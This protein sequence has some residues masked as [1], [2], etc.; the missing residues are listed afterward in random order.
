MKKT[1]TYNLRKQSKLN[2]IETL[3]HES[4]LLKIPIEEIIFLDKHTD[5]FSKSIILFLIKNNMSALDNTEHFNLRHFLEL[6]L[7]RHET[8]LYSKKITTR[9]IK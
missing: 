8:Y 5:D 4:N 7:K 9:I 2:N 1:K 6:P 3:I